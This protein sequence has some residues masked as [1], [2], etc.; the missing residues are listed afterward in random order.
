MKSIAPAYSKAP[1][2]HLNHTQDFSVAD[3][4]AIGLMDRRVGAALAL[5]LFPLPFAH[6][7]SVEPAVARS[8]LFP[9]TSPID[10]PPSRST[11]VN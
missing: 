1:H 4:V 10:L 9:G 8:F 6:P 5:V 11:V 2:R 7:P 3:H